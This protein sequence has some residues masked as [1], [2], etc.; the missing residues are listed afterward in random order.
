[1]RKHLFVTLLLACGM[2]LTGSFAA[3]AEPE[4]Q[5]QGQAVQTITG[6]VLDE[7][8]EPVIGASVYE[9]GAK[10]NAA[11]TNFEGN[12]TLRVRPGAKIVVSYVGYKTVEIAAA[13]G[14]TVYMQPTTEML[15][16]LVA[17]GYGSQKRANLTGAVATVDVAKVMDSRST[18]DVTRALQGAVP[19][20]TITSSNGDISSN[21]NIRIRGMGSLTN[22]QTSDPLIVV[23]GVPVDDLSFVNPD[24]VAEISVLKDA[25]SASIYGTRAAFGVILITTKGATKKDRVSVS[26]S[27]NFAWNNATVLPK[28][29]T[30]YIDMETAL[31]SF[32][33]T[34]DPE[35]NQ[36]FGLPYVDL[37]PYAKKWHEQ[38]NGLYTD[39]RE[40]QPYVDENN[41]GDY[42]VLD[43]GTWLRYGE[44]DTGKTLFRSAP[45][46]KHNVTLEG[47][48]GKTQYRLSFGYDSREG[49]MKYNP[50]K[51]KRYTASANVSTEIFSWL[52]AGARFNYSKRDYTNYSDGPSRNFY[53]YAWRWPSFF[54]MY[55]YMKDAD[56][57]DIPTRSA[58]GYRLTNPAMLT[59][60]T[61]TRMQAW[62]EANLSKY[63]VL[64]ADFTYGQIDMQSDD[65]RLP[66][67]LWST[68]GS[69]FP[70][71]PWSPTSQKTSYA[72]Q[73]TSRRDMWMTNVYATYAQTFAKAHNL[74]VMV[75]GTA[76][77]TTYNYF[78][79]KRTGLVDYNLPNLDLTDGDTY[80]TSA[81]RWRSA[82]A[83]F[84]GRINYDYNGIYLLELNA[85]YDGSSRL[86]PN[87]QWAF[88]PSGSVGYRFSEENYFAPV[89]S[90]WSNGK[91][92]A[93][94]GLVGNENVGR[95]RFLST[96]SQI[97]K[98]YVNWISNGQK[99]TEYDMPSLVSS[100]L[101]WEKVETLDLGLD[102]GFFDNSLTFGFDWY[103]RYTKDMLA[104]A[105]E[106]PS[107]LG[108]GSPFGNNGELRTRGWELSLGWNHSF[109][110]A[111]VYVTANLTDSRS[112]ITKWP[113]KSDIIYTYNPTATNSSYCEGTY[114]GDIWGFETDRYFEV[115]DFTGKDADGKWIYGPGVAKQDKLVTGNFTYGPGDIKFKDLDGDGEITNGVD[116][117][118]D[119]DGN[120]IPK[121]TLRNHG[122]LK[123]IGNALP[124]YEY[125]FRLGGAWKGFD[126]DLFFQGV[127]K[128][129]MWTTGSLI[130]PQS[131]S[132]IGTFE[133]QQS[134]NRYIV[135]NAGNITGYD[136]NQ[137][138]DYPA[139]WA[140]S[141][142]TGNFANIGRGSKN[143]YPQSRYLL[144]MAYLRLKN[145]T[146]GYTI[147]ADI[148]KKALIQKARIYFNAENLFFL[149][150]GAG[151]YHIDPEINQSYSYT[152]RAGVDDGYA[153][154]GRTTPMMRSYS[155]GIQ[156][157]F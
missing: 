122:D 101:T 87:D 105:A 85:R 33:R 125:S 34:H 37:I 95:N 142:T 59:S 73:S 68:W 127:G 32:Y 141:S 126:L 144:N 117:M 148:T 77:R 7:N 121:G 41:V 81:E 119:A 30:N 35:D 18:Q 131:Q 153:G 6:S 82:T 91:I 146:F 129:N 93:S 46:Q 145:L 140:G 76:E 4:P 89:K 75:G 5:A 130:I 64:H 111:Q 40:L 9:K 96:V 133:H 28:F 31:Q 16:E 53:Q 109:G 49:L 54:E 152:S 27:N 39:Y 100:S 115:S 60:T 80:E 26:Y 138:Y 21:P 51:L 36:I 94:Y 10:A 147:P 38:H 72:A 135:D 98:S 116:G 48:S 118:K 66:Q 149:Y 56:G 104:P 47:Q 124:R 88:F 3:Y 69:G 19:G 70:S 150:N 67:Y 43:D 78:Y 29:A 12:F 22:G 2:P 97:D 17:I 44:W 65:A 83:G 136:I 112:K 57:Q 156:V 62:M 102:L 99:I 20:L 123:V 8:N 103:Q 108:T 50:D 154:F 11:A 151:K 58:L 120:E 157:T 106:M 90:W 1:M 155:F 107:V 86:S 24:D 71:S 63:V 84:F 52:K 92:R 134:Y 23:D 139:C 74:K 25:A 55:G 61:Q 45:A 113:S 42:R 132:S 114:Y 137:D 13:Q 128:R 79:A 14:M 15:N 143:Y 110:D